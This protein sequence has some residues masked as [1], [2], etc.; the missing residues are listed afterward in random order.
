MW[1][2]KTLLRAYKMAIVHLVPTSN[3]YKIITYCLND[4]HTFRAHLELKEYIPILVNHEFCKAVFM[5]PLLK[6]N[7][8]K[9]LLLQKVWQLNLS[10]MVLHE[11]MIEYL[12]QY[13]MI[14][15]ERKKKS[16]TNRPKKEKNSGP[17][18]S[19]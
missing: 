2:E 8:E 5:M 11:D 17:K 12:E 10:A 4:K 1:R 7:K 9:I 18:S 16:T 14:T 3:I 19:S 15:D 13:F 6:D